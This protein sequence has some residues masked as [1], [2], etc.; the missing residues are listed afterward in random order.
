MSQFFG[1][2]VHSAYVVPDLEEAVDRMI[3]AG[4]GPAYHMDRIRVAGRY[5]GERNDPLITA[6][7]MYSGNLQFEFIEQHDDTPSAYRD[8]LALNPAGG[9][10]HTAYFS[11]DFQHSLQQAQEGGQPFEIVQEFISEDGHPYEIY[12]APRGVVNPLY[13]QLM[14]PGPLQSMLEEM[15]N[16]TSVWT[17]ETPHRNAL[18]LLPP[19]MQPPREPLC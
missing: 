9:L 4:I 17:G 16:A 10:H 12:V 7:F 13:M 1:K 15:E 18:D 14:L 6:V 2:A 3:R 11:T 8:F 19:E 5:R